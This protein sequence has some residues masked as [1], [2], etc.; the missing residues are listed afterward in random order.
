MNVNR[1]QADLRIGWPDR[2]LQL[3][4]GMDTVRVFHE[5][6]QQSELFQAEMNGLSLPL[7]S[8]AH[9]VQAEISKTQTDRPRRLLASCVLQRGVHAVKEVR[10][11]K[12]AARYIRRLLSLRVCDRFHS[13]Y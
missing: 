8:I 2:T 3:I 5:M 13:R 4:P 12:T 11:A 6:L 9:C 1:P 7:D 10:G